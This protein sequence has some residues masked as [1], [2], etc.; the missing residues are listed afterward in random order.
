MSLI[1]HAPRPGTSRDV[2]APPVTL[3]DTGLSADQVEHLF[4]RTLSG[5]ELTG[6]ALSEELKLPFPI[7]EPLIERARAERLIEVKGVTGSGTVA[8]RYALTDLGR[9]RARQYFDVSHYTGAAPVPLADYAA[10]M[11]SLIA[12]RCYIDSERLRD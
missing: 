8:Y 5:G 4:I 9:D 10:Y 2:L 7:L 11:Q 3:E 6:L 12:N 1:A